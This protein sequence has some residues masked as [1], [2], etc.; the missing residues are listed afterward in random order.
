MRRYAAPCAVAAWVILAGS[1]GGA[2][3]PPPFRAAPGAQPETRF[4]GRVA[5][6]D[7]VAVGIDATGAPRSGVGTQRLTI[8]G[9]GDYAFTIPA[10]AEDV[11]AA[12]GSGS[13]PGLRAAGVVW[14]GFASTQRV[15]AARVRVRPLVAARALPLR[16]TVVR[17]G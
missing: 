4:P 12:A 6:V 9:T 13:E 16:I 8:S 5:S 11:A 3:Q 7:R 14:Q 2:V 17:T 10:P 1:A 15:L